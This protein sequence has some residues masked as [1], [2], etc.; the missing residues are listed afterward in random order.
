MTVSANGTEARNG[1]TKQPTYGATAKALH[2]LTVALL[3]IQFPLGWLMPEIHHHMRPGG[4]MTIHI[5]L[6]ITIL[7]L[8]SLRFIWRI[9]HP[10]APEP[11]LP[12]WQQLISETVHW[13][14]YALIFATTM[15]GWLL[16]SHRGWSISLYFAIPLPMLTEEAALLG[17]LVARWHETMETALFFLIGAHVTAAMAHTFIFRDR[18]L[19][20][21]LPEI[22]ITIRAKKSKPRFVAMGPGRE[23]A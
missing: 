22:P 9:T 13:A 11:S 14:L 4:A 2:W 1:M 12:A 20:R 8:M 3:M 7:A 21:M 10:V 23:R 6:G 5:S 16:A 18:I 19:Q 17:G 15:T